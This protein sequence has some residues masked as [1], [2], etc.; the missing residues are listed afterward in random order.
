MTLTAMMTQAAQQPDDRAFLRR[1]AERTRVGAGRV[2]LP[3][4]LMPLPFTVSRAAGAEAVSPLVF[5]ER[6]RVQ[7]QKLG[8][9]GA[10]GDVGLPGGV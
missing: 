2:A 9:W 3:P 1:Q 5:A 10:G 7:V 6:S 8:S 4:S